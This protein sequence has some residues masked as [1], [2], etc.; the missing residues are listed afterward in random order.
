MKIESWLSDATKQ[1]ALEG[2]ATARLD[3]LV[4]LEDT[5][6]VGRAQLLAHPQA[7]LSERDTNVLNQQIKQR[8][9]HIP[10]A[11][12]RSK[13]EFYGRTFKITPAVL[14][15]RPES[16]T[17]IDIVKQIVAQPPLLQ[18][19]LQIGYTNL[20]PAKIP[21]EDFGAAKVIPRKG[22]PI[23]IADVGSGSGA[24]GITVKL[25]VPRCSVD[26]LEIDSAALRVSQANVV[27]HTL[28]LNVIQS[29]LLS[30]S[31]RDYDVLLCNLPYVPD[32]F[33]INTA[34]SHEPPL[35]IF[36]GSDGLSV[37][38]RLFEDIHNLQQKPLYILTEA[39]PGQHAPLTAIAMQSGYVCSQTNDFIQLFTYV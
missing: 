15:P 32:D 27:L 2:I 5:T 20:N 22:V 18:Q 19:K 38:R 21:H 11:Y 31:P 3:V 4:L 8:A 16:E 14:E 7:T 25:E 1:L 34:A 13:T 12:I 30:N 10:L 23:R 28:E 24:L 36:G 17:M 37:Y 35:A 29:D 6:G 26:L 33:H 9:R 39:L